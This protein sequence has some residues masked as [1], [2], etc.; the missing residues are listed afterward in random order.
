MND[1]KFTKLSKWTK[2][3]KEN[4]G[5][6]Q[7]TLEEV[8]LM[9]TYF[10][11][12]KEDNK[13]EYD[14]WKMTLPA[15]VMYTSDF[16]Q[17][18]DDFDFS[19]WNGCCLTDIDSDK[20]HGEKEFDVLTVGNEL[21]EYLKSNHS[22]YFYA[23]QVS[24]SKKGFHIIFYFNVPKNYINF[25]KCTIK[26]KE[27]LEEAFYAIGREYIWNYKGVQDDCGSEIT[28]LLNISPYNI[29]YGDI[30]N[31]FFGSWEDIELWYKYVKEKN[32]KDKDVK[33]DNIEYEI[34][35]VLFD[36]EGFNKD[37]DWEVP[38]EERVQLA[39][40]VKS[41]TKNKE[42][43]LKI[44]SK[45]CHKFIN[46]KYSYEQLL[47]NPK[48]EGL[49]TKN[50]DLSLLDKYGIK[51]EKQKTFFHLNENE[52]L[53]NI[54]KDVLR[55]C[56]VGYNYLEAPTGSGKTR[57]W[58]DYANS[59][60]TSDPFNTHK[61]ILVI[62]PLNS[63]I[64]TKYDKNKVFVAVGSTKL[65][66][67]I[68]GYSMYV[69]NYNHLLLSVDNG[70]FNVP[71]FTKEW[72]AQFE[73][74]VIDESHIFVK[75]SY[76]VNVTIPFIKA[77]NEASLTTKVILQTATP[78]DE[79]LLFDIKKDIIVSKPVDKKLKLIFRHID[80]EDKDKFCIEK[81]S[82]LVRYYKN[83][84]RK[85]YI[86]WNNAKLSE[87]IKFKNIYEESERVCIYHKK[88]EDDEIEDAD[89]KWINEKHCLGDK[90]DVFLSSV[91][92]GVGNDLNDECDAA[93]IIIGMNTWQED[94]QAI[95]RWRNSKNVETC[96]IIKDSKEYEFVMSTDD[97]SINRNLLLARDRDKFIYLWNDKFRKDK[98]IIVGNHSY[99]MNDVKDIEI[100]AIASSAD[101]Y[102]SGYRTKVEALKEYGIRVKDN[103]DK[104]LEC[105]E[106]FNEL[107]KEI[108][109]RDKDNRKTWKLKIMAGE[110]DVED[111]NTINK[112]NKISRFEKLWRRISKFECVH[113]LGFKK[114]VTEHYY[115]ILNLWYKYYI[116]LG[117]KEID[118]PELYSLLWYRS[119]VLKHS[120]DETYELLNT[121]LSY[122]DY[123]SI[124]AYTIFCHFKNKEDKDYQLQS[125]Y[126][127]S[128]Y[129]LCKLFMD[130]DS[131][132]IDEFYN[133]NV[134]MTPTM[135]F[136]NE[137]IYVVNIYNM[138]DV[139]DQTKRMDKEIKDIY[140]VVKKC[141]EYL[142]MSKIAKGTEASKK[143][144][145]VDVDMTKYKLK[146]GMRFASIKEMTQKTGISR[147]TIS[148]WLKSGQV[149]VI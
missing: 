133:C 10:T 113:N 38:Y 24:P 61:P 23:F 102:Y 9:T 108:N 136:F 11:G 103:Y 135:E 93:T 42:E 25:K 137:D 58:I 139:K 149:I 143:Q 28:R 46:D 31:R 117:N 57:C 110:Y 48:Y 22:K 45:L 4:R 37:I 3:G 91:Y 88:L 5:L 29:I 118:Y 109:K 94:I 63:I 51:Y 121:T 130:M 36:K 84:G 69:T 26:C 99:M 54:L 114:I 50:A 75:D 72:F 147:M 19:T 122:S 8:R 41:V 138:D 100:C 116:R 111:Y 14:K 66:N 55:K 67:I 12:T 33:E 95:G 89:V 73:A 16:R 105:N 7:Y 17:Y 44:W 96:I 15:V 32:V 126:F 2:G 68:S 87:L 134:D 77:L 70:R 20:Y 81:L 35:D 104:V 90:Y 34:T 145:E 71:K 128:F 80:F 40:S 52:F 144:I 60:D 101:D 49:H 74:V 86:Y 83:H 59:F 76:R 85:V 13:E 124:M 131:E 62:E 142:G 120:D 140:S 125:N 56:E 106:D 98:S 97:D 64:N 115:D 39:K 47:N 43:Y 78:M 92:F 146:R 18:I 27:I 107:I 148:R 1:I 30:N 82:C 129:K 65:P 6:R 132:L 123:L 127:S 21:I 79:H 112:D 119:E 141:V 53:G